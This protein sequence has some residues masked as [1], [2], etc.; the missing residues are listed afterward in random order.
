MNPPNPYC[1]QPS[2]K[3]KLRIEIIMKRYLL[4][5]IFGVSLIFFATGCSN[6]EECDAVK[7]KVC[8]VCG[9]ESNACKNTQPKRDSNENCAE[10]SKQISAMLEGSEG[11]E[12]RK[13]NFCKVLAEPSDCRPL[14]SKICRKCEK[15]VCNAV[16]NKIYLDKTTCQNTL[17]EFE[18]TTSDE[19]KLKDYCKKME[20]SIPECDAAKTQV[21]D[22]CGKDS[23]GCKN[24]P[25]APEECEVVFD[26]IKDLE[27]D[28]DELKKVCGEF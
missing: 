3:T 21:C 28:S 18:T 26:K 24:I 23:N 6:T 4:T 25:P 17:E 19:D 16:M 14:K 7:K 1:T 20:N 12:K 13:K 15:E 10:A 5:Y 9:E 2:K 22:K 11:L 27:S 8:D